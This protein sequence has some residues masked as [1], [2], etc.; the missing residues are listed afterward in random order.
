MQT[1]TL[2]TTA[3]CKTSNSIEL[4]GD[5]SVTCIH[6]SKLFQWIRNNKINCC[7]FCLVVADTRQ[8]SSLVHFDRNKMNFSAQQIYRAKKSEPYKLGFHLNTLLYRRSFHQIATSCLDQQQQQHTV[9]AGGHW[10][11][12]LA[13]LLHLGRLAPWH[14]A[15]L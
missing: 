2:V 15:S 7:V 3:N 8:F 10:W 11:G 13:R 14:H 12:Q 4:N 1:D 6:V 5:I 9:A